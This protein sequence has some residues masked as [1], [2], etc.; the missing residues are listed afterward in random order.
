MFDVHEKHHARLVISLSLI[1]R[2]LALL[3]VYSTAGVSIP[4]DSSH[5]TVNAAPP[6]AKWA[7]S[8]LRWDAFHFT[9]IAQYGYVYEYEYAFM[10]GTPG[11]MRL[12]AFI[13]QSLGVI[14]WGRTP[15]PHELSICGFI[16]SILLDPTWPLYRFVAFVG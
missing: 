10:P 16:A 6:F 15:S 5:L 9:H 1:A 14:R 8:G 12:A 7:S 13:A 2:M 11:I 4:F 3:V